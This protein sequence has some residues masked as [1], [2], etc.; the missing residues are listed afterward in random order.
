MATKTTI[1]SRGVV[2]ETIAGSNDIL[3]IDK[4]TVQ[5][6]SVS[7]AD[8]TGTVTLDSPFHV[9]NPGDS[10]VVTGSLP[11]IGGEEVGL[12]IL[13]H[14]DETSGVAVLSGATGQP[15]VEQ[16]VDLSSATLEYKLTG[17]TAVAD[18]I[19]SVSGSSSYHWV[20]VAGS[21]SY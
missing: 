20:V 18:V 6:G 17:A 12:R 21:G 3:V 10:G 11:T 1:D 9:L 8:V 19:A 4:R 2:T 5:D 15:V 16:G 13:V 7:A 14:K